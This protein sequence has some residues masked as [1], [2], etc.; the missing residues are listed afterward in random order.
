MDLHEPAGPASFAGACEGLADLLRR[1]WAR[2]GVSGMQAGFRVF[3][4]ADFSNPME[5]GLS[6]YLYQVGETA[7]RMGAPLQLHLLLTIWAPD[8]AAEHKLA[9]WTIHT[10][11]ANPVFPGGQI[12]LEP[13][14]AI[15]VVRL[16]RAA[17]GKPYRLSLAYLFR[18]SA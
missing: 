3:G 4:T 16:W 6:V 7:V 12:L 18:T 2:S 10:L 5:T 9:E 14:P 11:R 17:T 8:A 1:E 15:D 13:I